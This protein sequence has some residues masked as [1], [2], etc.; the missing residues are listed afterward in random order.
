MKYKYFLYCFCL[1]AFLS[2]CA[3]PYQSLGLGGG[4]S[5]S[6]LDEDTY[7]VSFR[8]NGYTSQEAVQDNLLRRCAELT[9]QNGYKYFV[10]LTGDG[11]DRV[12]QFSTPETV[13]T[14]GF[15]TSH[16]YGNIY[17]NNYTYNGFANYNSSTT[18]NPS[19][20]YFVHRY[21]NNVIIK[22]LKNK[23]GFPTAMNAEIMMQN[24]KI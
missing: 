5:E 20:T 13:N 15:G 9:M 1:V 4:Y 2:G 6:K 10:I 14:T 3:T 16:G 22:M 17:P 19:Q 8:G 21:S 24:M 18:V 11:N 7:K 23:K 12:S